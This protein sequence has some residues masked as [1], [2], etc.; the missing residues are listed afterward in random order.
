MDDASLFQELET[1]AAALDVEIRYDTFEGDGGLC[2]ILQKR[3]I[4]INRSLE[5]AQ[6]LQLLCRE[7][8]R[9]GLDE[10][11]IRP[12]VREILEAHNL[13]DSSPHA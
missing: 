4:I 2:R 1:L 9:C 12:H 13:S 8:A 5:S 11:Y 3:Y 6:R 10:V 7:L